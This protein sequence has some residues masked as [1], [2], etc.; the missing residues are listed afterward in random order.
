LIIDLL[1]APGPR[2]RTFRA[3]SLSMRKVL[4][5]LAF[6]VMVAP[7]GNCCLISAAQSQRRGVSP[8][9]PPPRRAKVYRTAPVSVQVWPIA[10]PRRAGLHWLPPTELITAATITKEPGPSHL[11]A[12]SLFTVL[13]IAY[14]LID[15]PAQAAHPAQ[16]QRRNGARPMADFV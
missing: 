3:G 14:L 12:I 7:S 5:A 4:V 8:P 6:V 10:L 2:F 11:R 9:R 15:P 16:A 13:P 1:K